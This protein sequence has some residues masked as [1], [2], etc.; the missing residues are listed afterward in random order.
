MKKVKI[1]KIRVIM[2]VIILLLIVINIIVGIFYFNL[3]S[4]D[5]KK[6]NKVVEVNIESGMSVDSILKLLKE[7]NVIRSELF[8]KI[9]IKLSRYNMQAGI[10]ELNTSDSSIKIIKNISNGK[11]TNKYNLRITFKEG[12]NA[13]KIAKEIENNTNNKYEDIIKIFESREFAKE[14][15]DAYWFLDDSILNENIYYPLE[16]YLFP[17]TYEFTD[18]DVSVKTIIKTMLNE[19]G[20]KISPYKKEIEK[21]EF[22]INELVILASI[23]EVESLPGSDR[24]GVVGV[25]VNRLKK[26]IS[27]G[28][29]MTAYYAYKIDDFKNGGLTIEQFN[30]CSNPYNTRC[31]NKLGLPVGAISNPGLDS[32]IGAIEYTHTDF[33]FYV[34][35]CNGK[36]YF[37]KT[38]NEI[39]AIINDL[40]NKKMWCEVSV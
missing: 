23:A 4:V 30:N 19:F 20:N 18:K 38:S 28:S 36:T 27:L 33:L 11:V 9:Y 22:S 3:K 25:S 21:S 14:M 29:D 32:L 7:N 35:D 5:N 34:A 2:A 12:L 16:G 1:N 40:R 31:V 6:N 13:R 24:K 15:V 8:S 37:A 39:N 10:Y 26:N 17:D